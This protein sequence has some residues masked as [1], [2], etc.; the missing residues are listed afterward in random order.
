[1]E[2]VVFQASQ[3][4]CSPGMQSGILNG[5]QQSLNA[6]HKDVGTMFNYIFFFSFLKK[7]N[8]LW[9]WD[10]STLKKTYKPKAIE[11]LMK[12]HIKSL[13]LILC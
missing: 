4:R 6:R 10:N 2:G 5:A 1:M 7:I 11:N 3:C 13:Y 12:K 8:V 9:V